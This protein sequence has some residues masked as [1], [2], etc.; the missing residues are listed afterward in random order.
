MTLA[1]VTDHSRSPH[2]GSARVEV[3]GDG[4]SLSG[5]IVDGCNEEGDKGVAG[6][7]QICSWRDRDFLMAWDNCSASAPSMTISLSAS[8]MV[9]QG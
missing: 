3:G 4:A 2:P 7:W 1:K 5:S 9:R 8:D 6:E